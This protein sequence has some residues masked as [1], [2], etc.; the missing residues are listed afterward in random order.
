MYKRQVHVLLKQNIPLPKALGLAAP[1]AAWF[2]TR[3][4]WEMVASRVQRDGL[5]ADAIGSASTVPKLYVSL[6]RVGE[7][8][9]TLDKSMAIAAEVFHDRFKHRLQRID[10]LIGPV[11]LVLA[12]GLIGMV[13]LWIILPVY[14]V[15][16][17]QGGYA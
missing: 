8:Y 11:L 13:F 10:A 4:T 6:V 1:A 9:G 16:A 3:H 7:Q 5:L 14:D 17:L 2:G 15:V 12:G